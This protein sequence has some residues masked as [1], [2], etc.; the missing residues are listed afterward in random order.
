MSRDTAISLLFRTSQYFAGPRFPRHCATV[1]VDQ[2]RSR[3]PSNGVAMCIVILVTSQ[4]SASKTFS[5][6][7]IAVLW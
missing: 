7:T 5:A 3:R 4:R 2:K 1:A 6:G